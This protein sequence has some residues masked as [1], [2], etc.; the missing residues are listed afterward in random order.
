MTISIGNA[1]CSW[2]VEF[3][4]DPRNP[5]WE[6]VLDECARA[7]YDG[8]ELGPVGYMPEDPG[9][10]GDALKSRSL[11]LIGGV[12]FRPFHDPAMRAEVMEAA[13]R[14][15][16]A[17][18]AHNA[19]HLVIIDSISPQRA[20]TAGRAEEAPQMASD[21]WRRFVQRIVDVARMGRD[22]FGLVVSVHPHAA[23]F[24]DF[25]A[26]IEALLSEVDPELLGLCLDT[27]HAHYAGFDPIAFMKSHRQRLRYVHFKDI[28]PKVKARAIRDR[29]DFYDACAN[30]I[31]CTL[32]NGETDFDALRTFL[33]EMGYEGWCTVEQDCDPAGATSPFD[34]ACANAAFLR[35]MGFSI[36]GISH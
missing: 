15:C 12:I 13:R 36:G 14:T 4:D 32:G 25:K 10:L 20:R 28:D 11:A 16:A 26:E 24:L 5:P 19:R 27:G 34:D 29:L 17:L 6:R 21:E 1:P 23:G 9:L 7:G 30:G 2:G 3:A 33:T 8:I 22:E 31:F 35:D 18:Q